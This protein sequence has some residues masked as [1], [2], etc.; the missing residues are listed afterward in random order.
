VVQ[1]NKPLQNYE[2]IVSNRIKVSQQDYISL[3]N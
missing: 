2:K 1:K 3:S